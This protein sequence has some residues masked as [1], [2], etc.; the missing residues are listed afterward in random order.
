MARKRGGKP[1]GEVSCTIH[2]ENHLLMLS[3][4]FA[5][6][7]RSSLKLENCLRGAIEA[8]NQDVEAQRCS[9]G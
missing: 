9:K 1:S 4:P 2:G 3:Q 6:T 8:A 5:S 7:H